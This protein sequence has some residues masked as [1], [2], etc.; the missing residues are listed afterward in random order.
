M[1]LRPLSSGHNMLTATPFPQYYPAKFEGIN[2]I[3]SIWKSMG[4]Q[5]RLTRVSNGATSCH[6]SGIPVGVNMVCKI[7]GINTFLQ[8]LL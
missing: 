1:C 8:G 2:K 3:S 5:A 6:L 4:L 7:N